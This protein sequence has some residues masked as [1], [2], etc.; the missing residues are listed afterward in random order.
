MWGKGYTDIS[1]CPPIRIVRYYSPYTGCPKNV[2]TFVQVIRVFP[3][4][5]KDYKKGLNPPDGISPFLFILDLM[6]GEEKEYISVNNRGQR[7]ILDKSS[8]QPFILSSGKRRL[9]LC[10]LPAEYR[11]VLPVRVSSPDIC[12]VWCPCTGIDAYHALRMEREEHT[13]SSQHILP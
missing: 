8:H 10:H 9:S 12:G 2:C 13:L 5:R 4:E 3:G 11:P 7:Y 6:F 1:P